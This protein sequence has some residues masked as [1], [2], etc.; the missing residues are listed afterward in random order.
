[1]RR[2]RAPRRTAGAGRSA[3]PRPGCRGDAG[4][5][6]ARRRARAARWWRTWRRGSVLANDDLTVGQE[7]VIG[8]PGGL[9]WELLTAS[10]LR[11]QAASHC[12]YCPFL[13]R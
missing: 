8:S 11:F 6:R 13:I 3:R 10:L 12:A 5:R 9:T 1:G 4:A 2:T 7:L